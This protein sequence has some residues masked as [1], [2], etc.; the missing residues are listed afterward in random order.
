MYLYAHYFFDATTIISVVAVRNRTSII[1]IIA[2]TRT[3]TRTIVNQKNV[4][5]ERTLTCE[6][7]KTFSKNYKPMR[8]YFNKIT[9]NKCLLRHFAKF[10][11]TQKRYSSL[12]QTKN[13][14]CELD[15]VRPFP[16]RNIANLSVPAALMIPNKLWSF[17]KCVERFWLSNIN[18]LKKDLKF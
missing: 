18:C 6:Q 12:N 16:L 1:N 17:E 2:R 10:I 9:D 5:Q 13:F 11:Q 8:V 7:W 14:P 15:S 4:S 3:I